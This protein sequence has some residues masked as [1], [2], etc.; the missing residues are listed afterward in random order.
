MRKTLLCLGFGYTAR[1]LAPRL[2]AAGWRVIGTSREV[3]AADGVE[4]ITWPGQDV[5]LDG[6][7]HVL[8][9]IGPN[10]DGDP[11]LA[12]MGDRIATAPDLEWVGY[13]STTAVYG[14]HDG[15]W[16]DEETPVKP[17]SQRGDWRAL[18]EMQWQ[19]IPGLPLHIFRLAGI[20]GPGRGP[21]AK[22][23]AGKARRIIKPGQ[24]FSRIHVDDI[25]QVL[26]ASIAQ[27]RPG[28]IY[29][30]CDDDPA[31]P[32]DVLGHAAELLGLPM[33]A[34]VPF[35]EA[36]MTPM[37]RSFYGENKRVRN[38]RIKDELGVGL[39]YPTYREGLR[40]VLEAEDMESFVPPAEPPGV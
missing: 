25:A 28:A 31:P 8:N 17:T 24:V 26:A 12:A 5:P 22:L 4:M 23:M 29:N 40:A 20:Y 14:H 30:V 32:Q 7:T 21:F 10:A 36:G 34:E 13:L 1:A 3:A 19:A 39:L 6:V 16:V 38:R 18:A 37:A 33:P 11:V 35:D 9:S 15:A 2:M 27:P